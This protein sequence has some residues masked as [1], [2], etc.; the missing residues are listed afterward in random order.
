MKKIF[1]ILA[2]VSV[3]AGLVSCVKYAD[4]KT[5]PFAS[6]DVSSA[7]IIEPAVGEQAISYK[8]PVHVYN[9]TSD[10]SVSYEVKDVNA[11][12]GVDYTVIGGTGVLNFAKGVE[13]QE[14][15]FSISGQPGTF[16]GDISFQVVLKEATNNVA[17]GAISTAKITIADKDHPLVALFGDY[18]VT[19]ICNLDGK[20]YYETWP[21]KLSM[22]EGDVTRVWIS[23]LMPFFYEYGVSGKTGMVYGVVSDDFKTITIPT[24]QDYHVDL[25]GVF[26]GLDDP[27]LWFYRTSKYDFQ[28]EQTPI[29][30]TLQEDGT[31]ITN[32][33]CGVNTRDNL[34]DWFYYGMNLMPS[35]VSGYPTVLAPVK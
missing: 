30:F 2:V 19:G 26:S 24:P 12:Q 22:Y 27:Y 3:F 34:S 23:D 17:L 29:V 13:T 18:E 14:I 4:Y 28:V 16:T 35:A 8:L 20:L 33:D 7:K 10:C 15:E 32:D 1:K 25:T 31:Y 21:V 6:L 5:E 11:K 9:A